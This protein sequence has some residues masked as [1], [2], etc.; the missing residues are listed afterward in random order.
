MAGH[1]ALSFSLH[2]LSS[3]LHISGYMEVITLI[4]VSLERSFPPTDIEV[5]MTEVEQQ[6][7][8]KVVETVD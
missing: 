7:A 6:W 2:F 1:F 3:F 4:R 8:T 5:M